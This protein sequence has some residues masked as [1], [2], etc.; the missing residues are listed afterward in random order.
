MLRAREC[1]LTPLSVVFTFGPVVESIKEFGGASLFMPT[2]LTMGSIQQF[3][4]KVGWPNARGTKLI[5]SSMHTI[6]RNYR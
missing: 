6:T 2:P 1:T 3:S 5:R 4:Y